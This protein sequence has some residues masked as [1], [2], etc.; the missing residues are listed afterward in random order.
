AVG[1]LGL[2]MHQVLLRWFEHQDMRVALVTI[3]VSLILAD[4]LLFVYGGRAYSVSTPDALSG[5]FSIPVLDTVYPTYRIFL[6]VLAILL[7]VG[8]WLFITRTRFGMIVRAGVDDR[9]MVSAS[10]INVRLVFAA[11]FLLGAAL[12]GFAGAIG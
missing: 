6:M 9:D 7:G 1:V 4:Q 3:G 8:L 12:A 11:V 2:I 10:G 5:P